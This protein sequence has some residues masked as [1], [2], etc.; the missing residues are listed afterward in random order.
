MIDLPTEVWR[1]ILAQVTAYGDNPDP[2][3]P[4][5]LL[6]VCRMWNSIANDPI[7]EERL[8]SLHNKLSLVLVSKFWHLLVIDLLYKHVRILYF[9]Q[10]SA[11]IECLKLNAKRTSFLK[12]SHGLD[13]EEEEFAG[14]YIRRLDLHIDLSAW[15]D[16]TAS[17]AEW[18]NEVFEYCPNLEIAS[19][20]NGWNGQKLELPW[21]V[22]QTQTLRSLRFVW[23]RVPR[24]LSFHIPLL[25]SCGSTGFLQDLILDFNFSLN[26]MYEALTLLHLRSLSLVYVSSSSY[27]G[28]IRGLVNWTLPSLC[29]LSIAYAPASEVTVVRNE[30]LELGLL[31]DVFETHGR[32]LVSLD[33][34]H[35][36]VGRCLPFIGLHCPSIEELVVYV[37]VLAKQDTVIDAPALRRVS[38][39]Q[40]NLTHLDDDMRHIFRMRSPSLRCIQL[41]DI[42]SEWIHASTFFPSPSAVFE[43]VES[44]MGGEEC[45]I[46]AEGWK[47]FGAIMRMR[48]G[49]ILCANPAEGR[50]GLFYYFLESLFCTNAMPP[51]Q[52]CRR[53]QKPR[54][55]VT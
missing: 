25:E 49:K 47:S 11:L 32:N 17:Q 12:E 29:S 20:N 13:V 46:G 55:I 1:L 22:A 51:L 40:W 39:N 27:I 36:Q 19:L 18:V 9:Q 23:N 16:M 24:K 42:D 3:Q 53:D 35:D 14:S 45:E 52:I 37:G 15:W 48:A 4:P 43:T 28:S 38:I 33:V 21:L 2:T 54:I 7:E 50:R 34:G 8:N 6:R 41:L 10:L 31:E 26:S 30:D 44:D 5:P